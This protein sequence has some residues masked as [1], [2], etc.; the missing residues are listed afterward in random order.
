MLQL[1]ILDHSLTRL[2]GTY[3]SAAMIPSNGALGIIATIPSDPPENPPSAPCGNTLNAYTRNSDPTDD[4]Y[5]MI[6]FCKRFFD[7]NKGLTNAL[8]YGSALA[9]PTKFSLNSYVNRGMSQEIDSV[10]L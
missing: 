5:P 1:S 3:E 2:D 7:D 6:N 4:R 9:S 8:A 10:L